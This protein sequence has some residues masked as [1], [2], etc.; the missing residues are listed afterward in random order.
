MKLI[1]VEKIWDRERHC[2]LTDLVAYN[3]AYFCA[4]RE[5]DRHAGGKDGGIRVLKS[6]DLKKW[7]PAAFLT[8]QGYDLRDPKFAVMSNGDLQMVMGGSTYRNGKLAS[9]G[10]V[11]A[12][13]KNGSDWSEV[14][15]LKMPGEWLWQVTWLESKGY[16]ISYSMNPQ[17]HRIPWK[18]KLWMTEDGRQFE[19]VVD[20][21]V[22]DGP[23]ESMVRFLPDKTMV[24]LL[25]RFGAAWM[26]RSRPPYEQWEWKDTGLT[27]GGPNFL[28][29]AD[30]TM[31]AAT[32]IYIEEEDDLHSRTVVGTL[33]NDGFVP[34]IILPSGGD[35]GYPGMLFRDGVLYV[36]YYSSHEEK[37]SVYL[38]LVDLK[39]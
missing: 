16:G 15:N 19:K 27:M 9:L 10:S 31:V 8:L 34:E 35:T 25:R 17:D 14:Y 33:A 18:A 6:S 13:S 26:G 7:E 30:G 21:N 36:S 29:L 20:L 3:G 37:T 24:A 39:K 23:S 38:A 22:P 1:S 2:A 5:A 4:F 11:T 28:V 32:R 12:F